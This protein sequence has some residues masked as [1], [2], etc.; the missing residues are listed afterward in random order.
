MRSRAAMNLG[1]ARRAPG[2][3]G[4]RVGRAARVQT[5]T[6]V[7]ASVAIAVLAVGALRGG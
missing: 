6:A 3:S 7:V 4:E 1:E 2:P 5:W